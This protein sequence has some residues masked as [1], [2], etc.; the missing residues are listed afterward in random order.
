ML[1]QTQS[2]GSKCSYLHDPAPLD[3]QGREDKGSHLASLQSPA[4]P[5]IDQDRRQA[6]QLPSASRI[7]AKPTSKAQIENPREYQLGQLRR[8]YK[9][10]ETVARDN[11]LSEADSTTLLEFK[12][13]P[14]DPDFPFEM[15]ALHCILS[16]PPKYPALEENSRPSIN[17]RNRDIPR[18]FAVN[19][20]RGFDE[21][22]KE[23]PSATLLALI[24][25]LDKN[26]EDFLSAKKTETVKLV[27]N[28]DKRHLTNLPV[29]V[30]GSSLAGASGLSNGPAAQVPS[31]RVVQ[32]SRPLN[33]TSQEKS[34]AQQRRA[35]ETRQLEARLGRLP[36]YKK[37][38]DAIAYTLPLDPRRRTDLPPS[39]Q[40][41]RTVKL[42]VPQLYPLQA[43]RIQI[44]GVPAEDAKSTEKAFEE[45]AKQS[46]EMSLMAHV[47]SLSQNM[48]MMAKSAPIA[49]AKPPPQPATVEEAPEGSKT[50][51]AAN[52]E[53]DRSHI[54]I[55]PRPPEWTFNVHDSESDTDDSSSYDSE[56]EP[57]EGGVTL[58]HQD[59]ES[60]QGQNRNLENGTAL[61]F[62]SI[63]LY[64]IELL[65][66]T[67]LNLSIK[68]ERCK[69][70]MDVTGLK[71]HVSKTESCKK[72]ATPLTVTFRH[73]LI[74]MNAIRAGFLDLEGCT[75]VDMLPSSFTPTCSNC[76]NPYPAP[77]LMSVRGETISNVCRS[78]H[79]KFTLALPD[80][81]F[82]RISNAAPAAPSSGPRR[83]R[84]T[85]GLVAGTELPRRGR[86]RHYGRSYRWF[87]FSCCAKVY[88]CDR[89]HDEREA[90]ANEHAHRMLCG[91]CSRE[92]NYRPED[93]G[94]CHALLVG[95]KGSGFW[96]GG[97]GTRDRVRMSRKDKRKFR[98]PGGAAKAG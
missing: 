53:G 95:K 71:T 59:L 87:R 54:K 91:F 20:E 81:K 83:K 35:V 73:E 14:S 45:K 86:C 12:V 75:V 51:S 65:E 25:E 4:Q 15:D 94:V 61:S 90:H 88:A 21:L 48:H 5:A 66:V 26:L 30:A 29:R 78:C 52:L 28:A 62:P 58:D 33:F 57:E 92:Q 7:V 9:P 89:C 40:A 24:S 63:E 23:K 10:K 98:R 43:C 82:L 49:A 37:S 77:G 50:L 39:L 41:V 16:V 84:E 69:E 93:C 31:P 70:T 17:V 27:A 2:A 96:E 68:C 32:E 38:G 36:L 79:Q 6:V 47:N 76:S 80:L 46:K 56:D 13:T 44:E 1:R 18:G 60:P 97:K 42:L 64:G 67:T 19:V 34:Q 22:V 11:G 85:L 55:I 8:R 74:H 3:N 72:C